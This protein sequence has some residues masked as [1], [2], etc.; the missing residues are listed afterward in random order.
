MLDSAGPPPRSR[1]GRQHLPHDASNQTMDLHCQ[2]S[3]MRSSRADMTKSPLAATL[4]CV[5]DHHLD[6]FLQ[7][8]PSINYRI[9]RPMGRRKS[10]CDNL[11]G[12]RGQASVWLMLFSLNSATPFFCREDL[13]KGEN[14]H[15]SV[16]F[17]ASVVESSAIRLDLI[18]IR[19]IQLQRYIHSLLETM[20]FDIFLRR[21]RGRNSFSRD[22]PLR[23][24]DEHAQHHC[25]HHPLGR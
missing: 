20:I 19:Y 7:L 3:T 24:T 2:S 17:F 23:H 18:Y 25:R 16:A 21:Y 8:S 10:S 1:G 5:L 6:S 14:L 13:P 9:F 4:A 11:I 15:A 22:L 12:V